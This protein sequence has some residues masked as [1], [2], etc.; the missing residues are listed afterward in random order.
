MVYAFI[1]ERYDFASDPR[2][3]WSSCVAFPQDRYNACLARVDSVR[4]DRGQDFPS[5]LNQ[6]VRDL[7]GYAIQATARL[8]PS[9]L[10]FGENDATVD[11][12]RMSRTDNAWSSAIIF[13]IGRTLA[14]LAQHSFPFST[15]DLYLDRRD[16]TAAHWQAM[17]RTLHEMVPEVHREFCDAGGLGS[18]RKLSIRRVS[19]VEKWG[20]R[21]AP[22]KFQIGVALAHSLCRKEG[23]RDS[24]ERIEEFDASE[25]VREH[26]ERWDLWAGT[27]ES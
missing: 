1:D 4:R 23:G 3:I 16:V 17:L 27:S 22:S 26:I 2:V 7:D 18:Y 10:R 12:P 24:L 11:I 5:R 8:D 21:E 14:R 25:V 20:R 13:T 15:V 19:L 6:L 9:L